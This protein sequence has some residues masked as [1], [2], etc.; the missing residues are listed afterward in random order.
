MLSVVVVMQASR[1]YRALR[2]D[3]L[4]VLSLKSKGRS[5]LEVPIQE[6]TMSLAT[7]KIKSNHIIASGFDWTDHVNIILQYL[8]KKISS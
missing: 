6:G 7:D 4:T 5:T 3:W 2:R 1:K 8:S